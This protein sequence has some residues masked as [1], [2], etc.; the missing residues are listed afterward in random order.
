VQ[1]RVT[2]TSLDFF[3]RNP[4]LILVFILS[5][6]SVVCSHLYPVSLPMACACKH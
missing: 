2:N 6:Q 3:L 5:V 1:L 4:K